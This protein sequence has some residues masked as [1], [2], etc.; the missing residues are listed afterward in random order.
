LGTRKEG[1][2]HMSDLVGGRLAQVVVRQVSS[3][4]SIVVN[5]GSIIL[6]SVRTSCNNGKYL[7]LYLRRNRQ[8]PW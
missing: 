1:G 2:A 6:V 5:G 4:D 3:R 7:S 8:I